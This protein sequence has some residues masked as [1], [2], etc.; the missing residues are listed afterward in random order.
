MNLIDTADSYGP[1]VSELLIAEALHPYPGDS[2]DRHQGRPARARARASGRATAGPSTCAGRCEGSLRRLRLD[3]H[4]PLPAPRGRP[5]RAAARTRVGALAD[6]QRRGQDP[7]R[8]ASPTSTVEQLERARRSSTSSRSRTATAWPIAP[9]RTCSTSASADGHR[10]HPLV[11]AGGGD[12]AQPGGPV[13][14]AAGARGA[15]PGAGG[16]GLAARALAGHRCPSPARR[17]VPTSRRTWL[18]PT[19]S[20]PPRGACRP[21]VATA[22]ASRC[23][24]PERPSPAHGA[25][26]AARR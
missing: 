3:A 15:H 17:H 16:A 11:P 14:R 1:E 24:R 13:G 19:S 25:A 9:R 21:R 2:G 23:P 10:L 5:E 6:L 8:R 7:P 18:R 26:S 20:S 12:L 4:R 22:E